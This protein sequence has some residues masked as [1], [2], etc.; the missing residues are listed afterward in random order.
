MKKR[1]E[2]KEFRTATSKRYLNLDGTIQV[3]LFK[4]PVHFI[5]ENGL[6]EEIN[7]TLEETPDGL[8][9][10][11]SDFKVDF[12]Y[13]NNKNFLEIS[14]NNKKI[15][16]F[17]KNMDFK[18]NSKKLKK[19][20]VNRTVDKIKFEKIQK[21]TD[22]EYEVRSK[23]LKE[24][25]IL[26]EKPESN[27]INFIIQTDLFLQLNDDNSIDLFDNKKKVFKIE[28]PYMTDNNKAYSE[29]IKYEILDNNHNYELKII[30]DN[31]W[32]NDKDRAFPIIIDPTVT[33]IEDTNSVEDTYI[34]NGDESTTTYNLNKLLVGTDENNVSYRTLLKFNLPIIP[35]GYKMINAELYLY[36]V[37]KY[38]DKVL[39]DKKISIHKMNQ[40][41]SES[42]AKWN[43]MN[44]SFDNKIYDYS[45][46]SNSIY[47]AEN[48]EIKVDWGGTGSNVTQLVQEWYN[49]PSNNYG[50]MLKWYDETYSSENEVCE[51]ISSEYLE[52]SAVNSI[53]PLLSIT[54]SD[55]NGLE[56]YLSY[57]T[58]NHH[59]GHSSVNNYTGNLTTTFNIGNTIGSTLPV[60]I[61]LVYNTNDVIANKDYGFG[62]GIKPNIIQILEE[63]QLLVNSE[64][65]ENNIIYDV[66]KYLDE[67]GTTHYFYKNEDNI[68]YDED[69]LGLKIF[70]LDGNY[71]MIDKKG[72]TNKFVLRNGTYY[73]EEIKD[74]TNK[75]IQI[76][77]DPSNKLTSIIDSTNQIISIEY[78]EN[79]ITVISPHLT[80]FIGLTDNLITSIV[81]LGDTE[82]IT[83]NTN[84]LIAKIMN[85]NGLAIQYEYLND[86][87]FKISKVQEIGRNNSIGQSLTFEYNFS[88]TKITDNKG[89]FNTY[90]FNNY[91]NVVGVTGIENNNL[92]K[93]YGK[94]Y[95]FGE[96]NENINKLTADKSLIKYVNNLIEDSSFE[97]LESM[98]FVNG[99]INTTN[100][101]ST[102]Y[103]KS[104]LKSLAIDIPRGGGYVYKDF[105]LEKGKYYTFSGYIKGASLVDSIENLCLDFILSYNNTQQI[106]HIKEITNEFTRYSVT[107]FYDE[108]ATDNL[109]LIMQNVNAE[110]LSFFL[111]D[112]Q[113]E[114]GE[115]ANYHNLITNSNFKDDLEGWNIDISSEIEGEEI[116]GAGVSIET[117]DGNRTLKIH[118]N[119]SDCVYISKVFNISGK[120]GDTFNLSFW[121]KN[122][123]IIPSGYIGLN[124]GIWTNVFFH[125]GDDYLDGA[126]IPAEVLNVGSDNWQF[127]SKNFTAEADYENISLQIL[128]AS[129]ANDCYLT[130]FTLFKDLE[131]YSYVYDEN[132]NLVSTIDLNK[133]Q[134]TLQYDMNNQLT[135]LVKPLGANYIFEYDNNSK[136]KLIGATSPSGVNNRIIYDSNSNPT[137]VVISNKKT[138]NAIIENRKYNIRGKGTNKYFYINTNKSLRLKENECSSDK[139]YLEQ[140]IGNKYKIKH[141]IL[142]NY[143]VKEKNNE[144]LFEYGDNNNVFEIITNNNDSISFKSVNSNK[145]ITITDE[146]DLILGDYEE[147]KYQ[148]EFYLEDSESKKIIEYSAEYTLDG[149]F[150]VKTIDEMNNVTEY[151]VNSSD[152]MIESIVNSNGI[153]INYTYDSKRRIKTVTNGNKNVSYEY[154]NNNLSKISFDNN[155]YEYYYDEFNNISKFKV[156]NNDLINYVYETNNGNVKTKK[157]GNNQELNYTYDEFDR[158][159]TITKSNDVYRNYYDNLGRVVKI[160]SNDIKK[161]YE[162]D[163]AKRLSK[164]KSNDYEAVF[165]YNEENKVIIKR[166]KYNDNNYIINYTYNDENTITK[167]K[168]I[169]DEFNYI[170]D[171]LGRIIEKNING[172]NKIKYTYKSMGNKTTT[173]VDTIEDNDIYKYEYDNLGNIIKIFKNDSIECENIYDDY[174]QLINHIDYTNNKKHM[175]NYDNVG[176]IISYKIYENDSDILIKDDNYVYDNDTWPDLL[177]QINDE[178]I[179]YDNIG[180]PL[181]IGNK[182]LTWMNGRELVGYI[183]NENNITYKYD[184]NG[185]RIQKN[186]NGNSILYVLE[187]NKIIF[188]NRNQTMIYYIY[189]GDK[190]LGFK[191]AGKTYYYHKN[192]FD[193]IL[194]ILD[195]N[196]NEIVKYKYDIWGG[197]VDIVDESNI[198]LGIINPFRYRSYYYDSETNLYC[199]GKRYYNPAIKRFLNRDNLDILDATLIS[200]TDLNL[201]SYCDN[202]PIMRTDA[203]G[204]FWDT[205]ADV[206]SFGASVVEVANKVQ[207]PWAW[208]TLGMDAVDVLV[209]FV[210][211]TGEITRSVRV[212]KS[213]D[214]SKEVV[215]VVKKVDKADDVLDSAKALYK[216]DDLADIR[217]VKGSYEIKFKSGNNYVGKGDFNRA[218]TS[219]NVKSTKYNDEIEAILWK[220]APTNRDAFI[221]EYLVQKQYGG[222]KKFNNGSTI[223]SYNE[224]WS[225]GKRIIGD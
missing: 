107:I 126:G 69:G 127:L 146:L 156:N 119:P 116:R 176:N 220:S 109:R 26:K 150:L 168:I 213:V 144:I 181:T 73:L 13:L 158:I 172:K 76:N 120:A 209:P 221:D 202:N 124:A 145:V 100:T 83:Y 164:F 183:D 191:Y 59:F 147:N 40:N 169:D 185:Y 182:T 78:E 137:K 70:M 71:L 5:N 186:I 108:E 118:S 117:I 210:S 65:E 196:N 200:L 151:N 129:N 211:G 95:T 38:G 82:I 193:D 104:G 88:D 204:N 41:W 216:S 105:L 201:F 111:D 60:N 89:N 10:K 96:E 79:K 52:D 142:T 53:K 190:I 61:Y 4:E 106:T 194:G 17:P 97:S 187:G 87:N 27:I 43:D 23:C 29:N 11:R 214:N 24:S 114:E 46:S 218:L 81:S 62:M 149:R 171:D 55:F 47:Y 84:N 217:K 6:Y 165:D 48:D 30:L 94:T 101:T 163:F 80:T 208:A 110:P 192:I 154:T 166:Q 219:A 42:T 128:S 36:S 102:A 74:T 162:Y 14:L 189:Q 9:N 136:S 148:Q 18:K 72:N 184:E 125:Y 199:L 159:K 225:P 161:D 31:D 28:K 195:E 99:D 131:T 212:L 92:S 56:S 45:I 34:F 63:E 132:G 8:R 180:N 64:D 77:Y 12:N 68:Y 139:F 103:S 138:F 50:M 66:L 98:Y 152:G 122:E 222:L 223:N 19:D 25:I 197:L 21:D 205:I 75:T 58:Q 112:I 167:L 198:G 15:K 130:N 49:T 16:M 188:E 215:T 90:I 93:A 153:S 7:N 173:L 206:F 170:Y 123:S 179:T 39:N 33:G 3:E 160:Y 32:I 155:I 57:S 35:P 133:K 54:Y 207:D 20:N 22:I 67:D 113:L 91:G 178:L 134:D 1:K 140:T 224:I 44:S 135:K 37:P 157:Y 85:P 86:L 115:I 177:T 2:L 175:M 121:Y 174:C 141:T 51:F 203:S 143:Y